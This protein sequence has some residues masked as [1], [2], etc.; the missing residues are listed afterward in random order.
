MELR[1][2][3]WAAFFLTTLPELRGGHSFELLEFPVEIGQVV[4]AASEGYLR[5][6]KVFSLFEQTTGFPNPDL[7]D[8]I[9]ISFVGAL[10]EIPAESIRGHA[11]C[12]S[13]PGNR[14]PTVAMRKSVFHDLSHPVS[15]FL[16]EA[17]FNDRRRNWQQTA[18][19]EDLQQL[20]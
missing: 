16:T 7:E 5:D 10:L 6:L 20:Q 12:F 14:K 18:S 13:G 9:D 2:P 1:L 3:F 17:L 15:L 4:E 8:K 11:R 19:A